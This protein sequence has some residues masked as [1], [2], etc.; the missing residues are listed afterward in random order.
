MRP[1]PYQYGGQLH[2]IFDI[3]T[4][5]ALDGFVERTHRLP[6]VLDARRP[7]GDPGL[8]CAADVNQLV[9]GLF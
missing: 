7:R 4:V 3:T 2:V 6:V 8:R 5:T 9:H 1:T